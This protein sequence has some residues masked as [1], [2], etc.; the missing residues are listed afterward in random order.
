MSLSLYS[1]FRIDKLSEDHEGD[2]GGEEREDERELDK[3]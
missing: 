3:Q 1:V 2:G